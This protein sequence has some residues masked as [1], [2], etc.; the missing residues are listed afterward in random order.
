MMCL[1]SLPCARPGQNFLRKVILPLKNCKNDVSLKSSSG[2]AWAKFSHK[3]Y[4]AFKKLQ[5]WCVLKSSLWWAWAEL[6]QKSF[7]ANSKFLPIFFYKLTVSWIQSI[8]FSPTDNISRKV[9]SKSS[10]TLYSI[11]DTI[12]LIN[13][14]S[15]W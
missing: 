12:F 6:S 14:I 2:W 5:K 15:H 4:F 3:S 11:V 1:W 9:S 13:K 8:A 10:Q 7:L